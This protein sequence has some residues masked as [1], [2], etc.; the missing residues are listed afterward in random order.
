MYIHLYVTALPGPGK[1]LDYPRSSILSVAL[2]GINF[3]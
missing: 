2:R 3:Q 1:R